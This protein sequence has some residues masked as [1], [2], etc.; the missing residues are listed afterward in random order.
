MPS[1]KEM[2]TGE[3]DRAQVFNLSFSPIEGKNDDGVIDE[4][5]IFHETTS[6]A[7]KA[8]ELKQIITGLGLRGSPFYRCCR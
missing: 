4:M 8:E 7:Q 1:I 2:A 3:R 6:I 5:K